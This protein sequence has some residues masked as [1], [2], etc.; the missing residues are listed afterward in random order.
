MDDPTDLSSNIA[1][2]AQ[3][4][5]RAS[6]DSGS[7]DAHSL[8]DQ[9]AADKYLKSQAAVT[10]RRRGLRFSRLVSPPTWSDRHP[11]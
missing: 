10:K 11:Y 1:S 6:G 5:A 8:P 3:G 2:N 4:P 9:I 7:F